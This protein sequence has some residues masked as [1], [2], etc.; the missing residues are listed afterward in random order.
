VMTDIFEL[1]K[2]LPYPG[3]G[4][5]VGKSADGTKAQIFYFLTGRSENSRNRVFV[6]DGDGIRTQ[7]FDP[8]KMTD[9]SL[10]IYSPVRVFGDVTIVTNGDQTDTVY[11]A[12]QRGD[13]FE[14]ALAERTFEPDAP[15]YTPRISAILE[16]ANGSMRYTMSM[17]R[18]IEGNPDYCAHEIYRYLSPR[19]GEGHFLR[20][21]EGAGKPVPSFQGVPVLCSTADWGTDPG[22]LIDR[23]WDSLNRD[24]RVS[25][26]L[27]TVDIRSGER[28]DRIRNALK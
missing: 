13:T 3:R 22:A 15:N 26:F 12:L 11:E 28:E 10:I 7:A 25:L 18:T 16:T 4:L 27:R 9:P 23:I 19:A 21:Y 24:N 1:L 8:S 14:S 2:E 17:I 5:F 6:R 20:T